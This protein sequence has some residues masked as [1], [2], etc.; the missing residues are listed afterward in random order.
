MLLLLG[1]DGTTLASGRREGICFIEYIYL[2]IRLR[3]EWWGL[4][5]IRTDGGGKLRFCVSNN[6]AHEPEQDHMLP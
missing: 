1:P 5:M 3:F 4:D 6:A 2:Y